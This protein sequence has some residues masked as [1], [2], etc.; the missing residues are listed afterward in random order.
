MFG[1]YRVLSTLGTGNSSTVYLAEH[2]RLNVYRAIKCIPK[3]TSL[4]SSPSS[5]ATLL[6]NLNHPGI[7]IIYDIE[8]DEHFFYIIE[9]FIQ[10][11][12]IDTFVS[13]QKISHE[14]LIKFG[15]QLCDILDYLHHLMPYP[16][17]YQ[18]LKPEHIIVCG[19]Q[20]KLIDFGIASF[21]TGSGKNYQIYG[22][23]DFAAPEAL[24]GLP[25]TPS[26][27]VYGLGKVLQYLSSYTT[28][29]CS[30][31]FQTIIQKATAYDAA[32]RYE[33]VRLFKEALEQDL[34]TAC[35]SVSHL[36][37]KNISVFG[38]KPGIGTTHIAIAL[39]ST[40]TA[41]G[42]PAV[43]TERNGNNHL[44]SMLQEHPAVKEQNG[45]CYYKYFL[46]S[47]GTPGEHPRK[48]CKRKSRNHKTRYSGCHRYA[49]QNLRFCFRAKSSNL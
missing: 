29:P 19:N 48:N 5:E 45:I 26:A 14:L 21:F 15:I 23:M 25:V 33:T 30:T 44:R 18:D 24:N 1:K 36:T 9:E 2:I 20:I 49:R 4:V 13:Y 37:I 46:R 7:P 41:N 17:L 38:S 42:Y 35:P 22:T 47:Y 39:A 31:I 8:E 28:E 10:G 6:K 40:L 12:S 32:D 43:Y 3:D 16:I 34:K 27:D 11:Q